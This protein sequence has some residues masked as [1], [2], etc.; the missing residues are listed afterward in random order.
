MSEDSNLEALR[1]DIRGWLAANAPHGWREAYAKMS[2]A[3]FAEAQRAW[4]KALVEGGWAIPHWP[5]EWPGGG[6]S[7]AE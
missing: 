5:A 7:L 3:E 4:F 1:A 6:R 2:H